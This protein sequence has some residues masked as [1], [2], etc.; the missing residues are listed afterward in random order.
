MSVREL[1]VYGDSLSNGNHGKNAYFDQLTKELQIGKIRNF[2]V[3]SSGLCEGT[4]NS[5]VSILRKQLENDFAGESEPEVILIWHG[6]NDWYWGS[7]IGCAGEMNEGSYY[8]SVRYVT[9]AL[10]ARFPKALVVWATPIFRLEAP[11]GTSNRG[12]A[13]VTPN[14]N[15]DTLT[16]F[17]LALQEASIRYHF[18]LI[19]AGRYVNIHMANEAEHLEDHVHPNERGYRRIARVLSHGLSKCLEMT[20]DE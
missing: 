9:E 14:K 3:G 19:D 4:P 17:V 8:A 13:F 2:A 5:M 6:T 12:D 7:P 18:P 11:D 16:D 10:R 20:T 15:G 1:W